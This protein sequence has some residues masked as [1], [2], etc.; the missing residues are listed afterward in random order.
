M[1]VALT[2]PSCLTFFENNRTLWYFLFNMNDLQRGWNKTWG[3]ARQMW[4]TVH[5]MLRME[6]IEDVIEERL[7]N[8]KSQ[9]ISQFIVAY[10]IHWSNLLGMNLPLRQVDS[11]TVACHLIKISLDAHPTSTL[12]SNFIDD[13]AMP[14]VTH[15]RDTDTGVEATKGIEDTSLWEHAESLFVFDGHGMD[16]NG[17]EDMLNDLWQL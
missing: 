5:R 9:S 8:D 4:K 16:W 7:R 14:R 17:E 11:G 1:H 3:E 2:I 13:V 6:G 12:V 10:S 15:R